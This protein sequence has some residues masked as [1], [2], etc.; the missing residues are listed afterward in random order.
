MW[1]QDRR[2]GLNLC[3]IL[4]MTLTASYAFLLSFSSLHGDDDP[5]TTSGIILS[6][7]LSYV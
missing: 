4:E 7:E 5:R 6:Q 2:L 3:T 1:L